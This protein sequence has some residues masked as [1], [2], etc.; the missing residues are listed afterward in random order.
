MGDNQITR[1]GNHLT[2]ND[3]KPPLSHS[4]PHWR[5]ELRAL[6]LCNLGK[7]PI[8]DVI[9]PS[10]MNMARTPTQGRRDTISLRFF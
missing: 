2:S 5:V 10:A 9:F 1:N 6:E 3:P 4:Y 7:Y 8:H